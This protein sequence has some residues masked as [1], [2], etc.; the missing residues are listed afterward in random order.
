MAKSV[1]VK[2]TQDDFQ[3][4]SD[5]TPLIADLKTQRKI[6]DG[7]AAQNRRSSG[8]DEILIEAGIICMATV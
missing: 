7:S 4:I 6:F 3:R 1:G 5:K 2:L 8:C